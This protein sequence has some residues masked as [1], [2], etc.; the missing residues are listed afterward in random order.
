MLVGTGFPGTPRTQG[1]VGHLRPL[2]GSTNQLPMVSSGKGWPHYL[3]KMHTTC[4]NNMKNFKTV[5]GEH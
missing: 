2:S 3:C 5:T 4:L 1:E